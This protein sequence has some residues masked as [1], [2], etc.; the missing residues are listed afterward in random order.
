MKLPKIF[1]VNLKKSID[2]KKHMEQVLSEVPMEFE[3]VE[4]IDAREMKNGNS[5]IGCAMSHEKTWK[6]IQKQNLEDAFIMEDDIII[7]DKNA[8]ME[9]LKKRDQLPK[10]WELVL[11]GHGASRMTGKGDESSFFHGKSIYQRYKVMRFT[12]IASGTLSYLVNQN[13]I[14]CLLKAVHPIANHVDYQCTGNEKVVNLYGIEPVII[15]EEKTLGAA[16]DRHNIDCTSL[17]EIQKDFRLREKGIKKLVNKLED[18]LE[19]LNLLKF[20]KIPYQQIRR[21]RRSLLLIKK[22]KI[23]T[24]VKREK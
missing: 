18:F 10:D 23:F 21:L 22:Y 7:K 9:I 24:L 19:P 13:G 1:V 5:I 3:F 12:T 11:F 15:E 4:A 6:L 2:R 14:N 17:E 16:S 8:F 20:I